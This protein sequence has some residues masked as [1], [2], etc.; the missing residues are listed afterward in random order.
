VKS[1]NLTKRIFQEL[2]LG[3]EL[4]QHIYGEEPIFYF[5]GGHI[6]RERMI[7]TSAQLNEL[8]KSHTLSIATGRPEV[9]AE[10]ALTQFSIKHYF[11]TMVSEDNVV[12]AE[13]G[14]PQSLRKPHPFSISLCMEK[15]GY[16]PHDCV[17]YIGDMPDDMVAARRAKINPVGF[18]NG[19]SSESDKQRHAHAVLLVQHGACGVI[20]N[21]DELISF[22][23]E[24]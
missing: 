9:E 17:H 8:S 14:C 10:Y 20:N 19:N 23:K 4:F 3:D 11:R 16:T 1:G 2:Y 22:L 13:K 7:P 12:E 21:F 6:E 18:V 24:Q 5:D 15:S